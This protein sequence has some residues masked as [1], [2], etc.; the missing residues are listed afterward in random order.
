M[1][2]WSGPDPRGSLRSARPGS[3]GRFSLAA[4]SGVVRHCPS[5]LDVAPQPSAPNLSAAT[6]NAVS[7]PSAHACF[8]VGAD[9]NVDSISIPLVERYP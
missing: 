3:V 1:A 2:E 8:I 5:G 7:C 9:V 6:F 4:H